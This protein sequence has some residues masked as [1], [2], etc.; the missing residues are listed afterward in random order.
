MKNT[1]TVSAALGISLLMLSP[2]A[3]A[4]KPERDPIAE[5]LFPPELIMSNQ[6]AIGLDDEQKNAIRA[7]VQRAQA[8]FSEVQW[9][10]HD[11]ME[12][13]AS[14]LEQEPTDEA[15]VMEH[16]DEVLDAEREVKRTQLTLMIRIKNE[17]NAEQRARLSEL[18]AREPRE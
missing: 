3:F 15:A 6:N 5:H 11:A 16:L 4:Q 8:R 17:L 2:I 1:M 9:R 12:I 13:L 7:E 18:R 10:L 14:L